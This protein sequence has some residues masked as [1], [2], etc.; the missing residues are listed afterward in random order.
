MQTPAG[1]E[2]SGGRAVLTDFFT[3]I[4]NHST[5]VRYLHVIIASWIT[6]SLFAAGISAWYLLKK[7]S[8]EVMRPLLTISLF[9]F[10]LT[11]LIQFVS[12]HA[13][14]V[15]VA[16]TQPEKMAAF[17]ALWKT[18][19]GAPL[20]LFGIPDAENKK[21]YLEI[22]LPKMLSFFI[23]FDTEYE[24]KGLDAFPEDEQ[25]PV[26]LPYTTYHI[27]IILGSLYAVISFI[28][29]FLIIKKKLFEASWFHR[30]LLYSIP[31]PIIANEAGWI[32]AEV[33]RQ[34]WVVYRVMRTSEAASP[35]VPAWQILLTIILF[36]VVY[37]LIGL[38][39]L[40]LL[41]K[42]L[43]KGPEAQSTEGY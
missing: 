14:S 29:I 38:M 7:K 43:N 40:K 20:A 27:M 22:S 9:I 19:K 1:F 12:G 24:V 11:S 34:P 3:A 5:I 15:Q 37:T 33:G 36:T 8:E 32:A 16:K 4:V 21:T 6:G 18:Q 42:I 39:F 25:P 30:I 35:V 13:H 23:A 31:L 10:I 28:G 41:R 2:I 17:E 26:F